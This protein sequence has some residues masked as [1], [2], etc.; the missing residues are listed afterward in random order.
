M[1]PAGG[2]PVLNSVA[3]GASDSA[4]GARTDEVN[5]Q[6]LNYFICSIKSLNIQYWGGYL[7]GQVVVTF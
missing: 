3:D 7:V 4:T 2:S 1:R 5:Q 6:T